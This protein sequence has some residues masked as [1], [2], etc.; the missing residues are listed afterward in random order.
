MQ[1]VRCQPIKL[2]CSIPLLV[3]NKTYT[4]CLFRVWVRSRDEIGHVHR[5]HSINPCKALFPDSVHCSHVEA[6]DMYGSLA[7]LGHAMLLHGN[8]IRS[9]GCREGWK[10]LVIAVENPT[11]HGLSSLSRYTTFVR[12][13]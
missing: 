10:V 7:D 12:R 13:R 6:L 5:K 9:T 4:S 1:R 2:I 11:T 3:I 8:L